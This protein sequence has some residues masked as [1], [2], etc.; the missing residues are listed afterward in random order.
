[1]LKILDNKVTIK[2]NEGNDDISISA[3]EVAKILEVKNV[4]QMLKTVDQEEKELIT[5]LR[6]DG[7]TNKMWVLKEYGLYEVLM[8]SRKPIAKEFKK[9]IKKLLKFLRREYQ[10]AAS[11]DI[12]ILTQKISEYE[13]FLNDSK[14]VLSL[15]FLAEKYGI[16]Y[17]ELIKMLNEKHFLYKKG[18][19]LIVYREHKYK[20]YVKYLRKSG[21]I[22]MYITL[23]GENYIEQ[24][25]KGGS[26]E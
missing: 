3:N 26:N 4:S 25:F 6:E 2:Y 12:K 15:S 24:L 11:E 21:K 9:E 5:I 13:S 8:Q 19:N 18:K 1:M 10:Y 17:E 22:A 14:E 7:K 20:N 16:S 23:K